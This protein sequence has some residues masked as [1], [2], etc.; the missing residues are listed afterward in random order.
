MRIQRLLAI[1]TLGLALLAGPGRA[2]GLTIDLISGSFSDS[3]GGT[4]QTYETNVPV[5]G[6]GTG[7]ESV[8]RWGR[9]PTRAA[10]NSGLG[11]TPNSPGL[12]VALETE[13]VIGRMRHFNNPVTGPAV[14]TQ[15]TLTLQMNAA[16]PATQSF[17][18][19]FVIDE[20]DNI[21][22]C[23]QPGTTICPDRIDN[24]SSHSGRTFSVGGTVYTLSL[25]GWRTGPGAGFPFTDRFISEEGGDSTAYLVGKIT[26][27][28]V[29][30][31]MTPEPGTLLLLG[32]GLWALAAGNRRMRA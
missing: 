8:A 31:P 13:F 25:L 12:S 21:E 20:T 3:Q 29:P 1:A 28:L 11:F 26:T 15:L 32:T 6:F 10:P 2:R 4:N 27:N 22:P 9:G 7:L 5:A 14:E 30:E 23:A 17:P 19:L 18:Y 16:S 24:T